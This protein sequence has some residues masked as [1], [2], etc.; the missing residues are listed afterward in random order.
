M[1]Y[2]D[3]QHEM[4]RLHAV[5]VDAV[6]FKTQVC[7]RCGGAWTADPAAPGRKPPYWLVVEDDGHLERV[8]RS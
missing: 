6:A 2:R 1:G 3:C 4:N 5:I 8:P 7:L